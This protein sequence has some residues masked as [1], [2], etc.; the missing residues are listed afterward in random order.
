MISSHRFKKPK[1]DFILALTVFA[2]VGFGLMMVSSASAVLSYEYFGHNNYYL[3]RQLMF[4]GVGIIGW[5][6][7]Q[8]IDYHF[9][10][11]IAVP[12]FIV[13]IVL[14]LIVFIPHVGFNY[15]GATRW[16]NLGFFLLQPSEILKLSLIIFIANWFEEKRKNITSFKNIF[17]PFCLIIVAIG[18]IMMKQPDMGTFMVI[19]CTAFTMYFIAGARPIHIGA[20]I[21][22]GLAAIML[23][24]KAA[25]YRMSRFL[26]FL[27]P[28]SDPQGIGFHINQAL[29]AVGSGG[30]LGRG[31]GKS[32]Q[33]YTG[34]IPE[35]AGD[36]IFAII[37]EELGFVKVI[38]FPVL[39]F[40]L[41]AWRGYR[42]AKNASDFF[43]KLL[44]FGI[45]SWIIF[46]A[47]INI[48][49]MLS[50]IPLTGVPLPFISYGGSS[51]IINLTAIGVLLNISKHQADLG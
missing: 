25:P 22:G 34:Y 6:F 35:A 2:L 26:V 19:A 32:G 24:I 46:Q 44:A 18:A 28:E 10:K 37:A 31:F 38:I 39:L 21:G 20:M 1:I 13:S 14:A 43:G 9:W 12:F 42:I 36:S 5:I 16:I 8:S 47:F 33:K 29:I 4:C 11:K 40:V 27:N 50:L 15:G 3:Y 30:L 41:F 48:A 17:V 45:T 7:A 51:L 23:L 49:T